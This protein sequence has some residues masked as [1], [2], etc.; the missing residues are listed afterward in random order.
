MQPLPTMMSNKKR[1]SKSIEVSLGFYLCWRHSGNQSKSKMLQINRLTEVHLV[2]ATVNTSASATS[3]LIQQPPITA[4]LA[5]SGGCRTTE[6]LMAHT[7]RGHGLPTRTQRVHATS[8]HRVRL[9]IQPNHLPGD[10]S[11][12]IQHRNHVRHGLR[13]HCRSIKA[14]KRFPAARNSIIGPRVASYRPFS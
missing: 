12:R 6:C 8:Y 5:E 10:L 11:V 1:A 9:A 14:V 3:Q 4:S 13:P 2:V 7:A